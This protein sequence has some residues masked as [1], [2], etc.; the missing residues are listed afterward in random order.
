MKFDYKVVPVPDGLGPAESPTVIL[1]SENAATM[2]HVLGAGVGPA[3][4]LRWYA[5]RGHEI[6][7]PLVPILLP[8][9][10]GASLLAFHEAIQRCLD[11]MSVPATVPRQFIVYLGDPIVH[12]D[13]P[14]ACV[15]AWVGM[16]AKM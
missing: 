14:D 4:P 11:A 10:P 16:A 1:V 3:D 7:V 12:V 2:W 8:T 15:R 5:A 6:S 13:G 9:H